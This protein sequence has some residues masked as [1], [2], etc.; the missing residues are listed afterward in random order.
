MTFSDEESLIFKDEEVLSPEYLPEAMPHRDQEIQFLANNLQPAAKGRIPQNT[1]MFGPPG[2]GKSATVKFVFRELEDFSAKVKTVYI[3]CWDYK[4]A[5]SIL[6]RIAL[7]LQAFALRRGVGKDEVLERL[8]EACKKSGKSLV[9][10]LDEVDQLVFNEQETL[11]DLLRI[12]QYIKNAVGIVFISNNPHVF[13][14]LEPRVRSSLNIQELEYKGYN[15]EEMKDILKERAGLAFQ[16]FDSTVVLLAANHAV[17]NGGDVRVGLECLLKAGRE[18]ERSDDRKIEVKHLKAVL[19]TIKQVKLKIL[20]ERVTDIERTVLK[21]VEQKK[22]LFSDEL[23]EEYCKAVEEP[24]TWRAFRDYVK[25]LAG[26]NLIKVYQRKR[27][28]RGK[29]T[30]IERAQ[31]PA[32]S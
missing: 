24:V 18:A 12:N 26:L 29:K 28:V 21:I 10:C 22:K 8:I 4:S 15:L 2:V 1:F 13:A 32:Q 27:G 31:Q 9:I 16:S 25:H 30:V 5:H 14:G 17:N 19:P 20:E 3:N 6:S 23:Y 7:E 11:Y